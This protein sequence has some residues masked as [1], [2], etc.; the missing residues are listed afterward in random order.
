MLLYILT[1]NWTIPDDDGAEVLGVYSSFEKAREIMQA[2]AEKIRAE[3]EPDFWD[4]DLCCDETDYLSFG[5][6]GRGCKL[7]TIYEWNIA[8]RYLDDEQPEK[9]ISGT[10]GTSAIFR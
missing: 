10:A 1:N 4:D 6:F 8:A 9:I 7:D 2:E 5:H 3:Y